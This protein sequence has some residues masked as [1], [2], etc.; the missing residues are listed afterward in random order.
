MSA[1]EGQNWYTLQSTSMV[2]RMV[3]KRIWIIWF[4]QFW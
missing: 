1:T 4:L 2:V 3:W